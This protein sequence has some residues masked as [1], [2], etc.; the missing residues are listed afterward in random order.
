MTTINPYAKTFIENYKAFDLDIIIIG[1]EKTPRE[2]EDI[3]GIVYISID[4]QRKLY[5]YLADSIPLNS[6]SRKNIGY[7]HA[8]K[9]EYDFIF[10]TDDDNYPIDDWLAIGKPT[11]DILCDKII[12]PRIPNILSL[13]SEHHIWPR[14]FPLELVNETQP[15]K[16]EPYTDL[17][18]VYVW[19]S[20]VE[21]NPDVDAIFRLTSPNS[22]TDYTFSN[23]QHFVCDK[24]V[25]TQGNTQATA[26]LKSDIFHLLYLPSTVTFRFCDILKMYVMQ[27]CMWEY[28]GYF[29]YMP[30][31]VYQKRNSH[32]LMKDLDLEIHM[33]KNVHR[34]IDILDDETLKG[35][36]EDLYTIYQRLAKENIVTYQEP[37]TVEAW[38]RAINR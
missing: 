27:R 13:Y 32:D 10:E 28:E 15:I 25:Y 22:H 34:L 24:N 23:R 6:Y 36:P 20:L 9:N 30:P 29:G 21:G 33:Y 5:P 18:S 3:P 35:N 26:W 19:Q 14:G 31:M 11:D 2:Y 37:D 16:T 8:I 38:I 7:L 12:S 4:E 17:G 1:D